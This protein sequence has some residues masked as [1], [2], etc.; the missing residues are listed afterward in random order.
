MIIQV[1]ELTDTRCTSQVIKRLSDC[2]FREGE[3]ISN[4]R[5]LINR[6]TTPYPACDTP[7]WKAIYS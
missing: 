6:L 3:V 1:L 5:D 2:S 7:L 4:S